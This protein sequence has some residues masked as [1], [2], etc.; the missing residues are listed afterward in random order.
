MKE[1]TKEVYKKVKNNEIDLYMLDNNLLEKI[2]IMLQEEIKIKEQY[3]K[4]HKYNKK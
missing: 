4:K 3:L 1:S 2:N